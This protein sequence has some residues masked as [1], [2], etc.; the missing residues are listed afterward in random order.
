MILSAATATNGNEL[1]VKDL[2]NNTD[3]IAIQKGYDYNTDV[4]DTKGDFIYIMTDK[5][6]PNMKLQ[7]FDIKN[8]SVWTDVIP[9]T[10]NVLSASTG[11]G[12][13][14]AKNT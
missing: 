6:A 12:Y 1:Y 5:N 3:W 4:L 7:K 9:E 13:I 14:F 10:E 8:P 2:K 11:G